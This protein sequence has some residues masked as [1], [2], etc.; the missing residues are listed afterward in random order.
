M[1]RWFNSAPG[2]KPNLIVA[3]PQTSAAAL[4]KKILAS[5]DCPTSLLIISPDTTRRTRAAEHLLQKQGVAVALSPKPVTQF[6]DRTKDTSGGGQFEVRRLRGQDFGMAELKSLREQAGSLSLFSKRRF[7]LLDQ[8]EAL[9]ADVQ[10]EILLLADTFKSDTVLILL[11]A[12]LLASSPLRKAYTQRERCIVFEELRGAALQ[13]WIEK[14]LKRAEFSSWPESLPS[15]LAVMEEE[16]VD[17]VARDVE[18]MRLYSGSPAITSE[19]VRKLFIQ[20]GAVGEFEYL[21]ALAQGKIS[22]SETLLGELLAAGKNP[23]M[24]LALI[25]R[26][27]V[28][29]TGVKALQVEGASVETMKDTL[30]LTPWVLNK[31]LSSAKRYSVRRL[32]RALAAIVRADSKLKNR[33]LGAETI[34]GEL[35]LQVSPKERETS[36][37]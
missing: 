33:S 29:Y 1:C 2:H 34:F 24:L 8:A 17:A 26:S 3:A 28:N 23:F 6:G 13:Q 37:T 4:I 12:T 18:L 16:S 11:A 30:G 21:D 31:H 20:R 5:P 35:G 36:P 32:A 27:F 22:Q 14:E 10:K 7:F 19:D 15:L 25:A 9:S